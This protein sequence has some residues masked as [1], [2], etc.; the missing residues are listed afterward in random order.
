ME[1]VGQCIYCHIPCK[2][3]KTIGGFT[4]KYS[5][6]GIDNVKTCEYIYEMEFRCDGNDCID[7]AIIN[8][9]KIENEMM[10]VYLY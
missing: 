6:A 3:K 8:D 7:I 10:I 9:K 5:R 1:K 4:C 2:R